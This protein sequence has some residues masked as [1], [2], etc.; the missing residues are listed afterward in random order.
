MKFIL[1]ATVIFTGSQSI[2]SEMPEF[3]ALNA[4]FH[5]SKAVSMPLAAPV[6]ADLA[7]SL[8]STGIKN[9]VKVPNPALKSA[10][11]APGYWGWYNGFQYGWLSVYKTPSRLMDDRNP[12]F[13][14]VG[15]LLAV[16]LFPI[17]LMAGCFTMITGS[18]NY[19]W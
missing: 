4:A 14:I 6:K 16:I 17:A 19:I 7:A 13:V 10:L 9:S 2:A 15:A 18:S 3:A 11:P 8:P 5:G 12:F 1:F